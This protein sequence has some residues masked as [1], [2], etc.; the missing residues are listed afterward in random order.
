MKSDLIVI[1]VGEQGKISCESDL[2]I[3][4]V[5]LLLVAIVL[6]QFSSKD[7]RWEATT[8]RSDVAAL[9]HFKDNPL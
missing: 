2:I 1:S 6:E 5:V 7:G 8:T 9:E 4:I 3:V